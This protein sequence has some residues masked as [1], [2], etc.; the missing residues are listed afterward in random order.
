VFWAVLYLQPKSGES[1][2][3]VEV[4]IPKFTDFLCGPPGYL[5]S[6][7]HGFVSAGRRILDIITF[8]KFS[9]KRGLARTCGL[10]PSCEYE[11]EH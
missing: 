8:D 1:R 5:F 7:P 11:M 9:V 6:F 10:S 4:N 3:D 2:D